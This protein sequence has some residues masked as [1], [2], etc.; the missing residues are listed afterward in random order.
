M[1][2][3]SKWMLPW[4]TIGKRIF[5]IVNDNNAP[6]LC[7]TAISRFDTRGNILSYISVFHTSDTFQLNDIVYNYSDYVIALRQHKHME[8]IR[9]KNLGYRAI[10]RNRA[11]T[12]MAM[13]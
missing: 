8:T 13:L 11:K 4:H 1:S 6:E 10:S 7:H 9:L 3:E 5:N 12:I 2:N